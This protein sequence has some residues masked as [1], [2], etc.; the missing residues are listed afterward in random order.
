M[1]SIKSRLGARIQKKAIVDRVE[2]PAGKPRED[3]A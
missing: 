3:A 2:K 1:R